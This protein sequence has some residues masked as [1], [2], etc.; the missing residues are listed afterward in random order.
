MADTAPAAKIAAADA[1]ILL[2]G[3]P[4]ISEIFEVESGKKLVWDGFKPDGTKNQYWEN[5]TINFKAHVEGKQKQGGNLAYKN[6]D[7]E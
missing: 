7:G 3:S 1:D 5:E 2:N 4:N 6:A